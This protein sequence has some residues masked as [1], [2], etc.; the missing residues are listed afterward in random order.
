MLT[1]LKLKMQQGI[2]ERCVGAWTGS[3]GCSQKYQA[4]EE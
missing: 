2:V 1:M 4:T 3:Y